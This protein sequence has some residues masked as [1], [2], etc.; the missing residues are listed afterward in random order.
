MITQNNIKLQDIRSLL[1]NKI[2]R[3]FKEK[4]N[5]DL[6]I[7][8]I[9]NKYF[10]VGMSRKKCCDLMNTLT[11]NELN[12]KTTTL[13]YS[14]MIEI[15]WQRT[16]FRFAGKRNLRG[17]QTI[18]DQ[19]NLEKLI[20]FSCKK[21]GFTVNRKIKIVSPDLVGI[22]SLFCEN[23]KSIGSGIVK[24]EHEGKEIT[25]T[26]ITDKKLKIKREAFL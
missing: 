7:G 15:S 23:C 11:N 26:L 22:G 2:T 12:I 19:A 14:I 1:S 18:F 8:E 5:E 16:N 24:F 21:C 9:F 4:R 25:K 20:N 6:T 3:Y 17:R 13:W 10:Q